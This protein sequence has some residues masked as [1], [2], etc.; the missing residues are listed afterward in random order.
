MTSPSTNSSTVFHA[1]RPIDL[2]EQDELGR[3]DF[4]EQF[5]A[6]MRDHTGEDSLV[7]ALNG[8]WGS[9]KS[10]IWKLASYALEK[11]Q[12]HATPPVVYFPL[13]EISGAEALAA[14]FFSRLSVTVDKALRDAGQSPLRGLLMRY[15]ERV[16]GGLETV[17]KLS[18]AASEA[19]LPWIGSVGKMVGMVKGWLWGSRDVLKER[20]SA[21]LRKLP[22]PVIVVF[23]DIDRL[24]ADEVALLFRLVKAN[25]DFPRFVYVLLFDR[26]YARTAL[27][28][29]TGSRGAE[30]IEKIVQVTIDVPAP[31]PG[32]IRTILDA[33]LRRMGSEF[34]VEFT[35][36]VEQRLGSLLDKVLLPVVRHLRDVRRYINSLRFHI[37]AMTSHGVLQGNF[38]DLAALEAARVWAPIFYAALP[39]NRGRLIRDA[40]W[41]VWPDRHG[42]YSE[43]FK[44]LAGLTGE[45]HQEMSEGILGLVFGVSEKTTS[46]R[47]GDELLAHR[48]AAHADFFDL[49][50]RFQLPADAMGQHEV[51]ALLASTESLDSATASL[52]RYLSEGRLPLVL[53]YLT[54]HK[55]PDECHRQNL[56]QALV[57]TSD[58]V[59]MSNRPEFRGYALGSSIS[60]TITSQIIAEPDKQR[61]SEMVLEIVR[62]ARALAG[63]VE[64]GWRDL[65]DD[66]RNQIRPQDWLVAD[67]RKDELRMALLAKFSEFEDTT[68]PLLGRF[69]AVYL[70]LWAEWG[71]KDPVAAWIRRRLATPD[72]FL[73]LVECFWASQT[74]GGVE[75]L[76]FEA[77]SVAKYVPWSEVL[78][79]R[80]K[81]FGADSIDAAHPLVRRFDEGVERDREKLEKLGALP[82]GPVA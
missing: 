76:F 55:P 5:G 73:A 63:V 68:L 12:H 24:T 66:R 23:D 21:A 50:F 29:V 45:K 57:D 34:A 79:A 58:E 26:E 27:D 77:A 4:A 64:I 53:D 56:V 41:P 47:W 52:R 43:W 25:G 35:P 1:E 6:A 19:G 9:G 32:Q 75:T 2:P 80:Q 22:Q 49:H 46:T 8:A 31:N 10:S 40:R 18:E 60:Q 38:I 30:F 14:E 11:D 54:A 3:Y 48:R 61:R 65:V 59:M 37:R 36:W 13:W 39:R 20:L 33:E 16:A 42:E 17:G 69:A 51:N 82:Q 28:K 81:H 62:G 70:V 78:A 71:G 15:G 74:S 72:G 7:V 67:E 44:E